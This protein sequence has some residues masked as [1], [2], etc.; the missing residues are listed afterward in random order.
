MVKFKNSSQNQRL[1]ALLFGLAA[2][3]IFPGSAWAGADCPDATPTRIMVHV[4][5]M[6]SAKGTLT[7]ALYDDNERNFLRKGSRIA[8]EREPASEDTVVVCM[9]APGPG[10]YAIALYHDDNANRK[11]DRNWYGKP[12]EG[13]AFSNNAK[14][15]LGPPSYKSAAFKVEGTE[16]EIH[17]RMRY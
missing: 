1:S 10:E 7:A 5:G 6:K 14:G 4:D 9:P 13:W 12:K 3:F 16:I 15:R 11:F 8:K 2:L 17:I